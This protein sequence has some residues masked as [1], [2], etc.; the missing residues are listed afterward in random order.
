[1]EIQNLRGVRE[2]VQHKIYHK[3][4]KYVDAVAGQASC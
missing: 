1:M 4:R 2:N 3:E